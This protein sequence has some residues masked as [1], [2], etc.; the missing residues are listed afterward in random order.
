MKKRGQRGAIIAVLLLGLLIFGVV[1]FAWTTVTDIFQP[2]SAAQGKTIAVVVKNGD[3]TLTIAD[4]LQAKGLIR[5]ALAFR[6]WARIKGLD[7]HLQ[8]GAYN[9]NSSMTIDAIISQLLNAG[10]DDLVVT[11]PEG[12]RIEQIAQRLGAAGL[13]NFKTQE[14]LKYTKNPALFLNA[15]ND[16]NA[17]NYP[18]LKS[19]PSGQSMEGLL[20]PD[21]YLIPVNATAVDVVNMMLSEFNDKI[22][23][24]HLDVLAKQSQLSV[25]QMVILASIVER[26]I[27][28]DKDR[29]LVASVYWNRLYRP[30]NETMGLLEADPTVQYARDSQAGT[31][32]YWKPLQDVGGNIAA[33][34]PWNTYTHK[35]FPPTPICSPGLASMLAAATPARTDYYFFLSKK[36]GTNVYAKTLAE[37]EADKQNNLKP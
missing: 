36:D 17:A 15:I 26:E 25:Y 30:N 13:P 32:S 3:S 23:R 12:W 5:N 19:I 4:E 22:Q 10:P 33:N 35:G 24:N 16:A 7:T 37:F 28:F 14:F 11:I 9:L 1:Y 20:F 21:T 27:I 8:A 2:E 6:V 29:P 31:T 34:S 18:I